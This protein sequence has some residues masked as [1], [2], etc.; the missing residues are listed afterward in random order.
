MQKIKSLFVLIAIGLLCGCETDEDTELSLNKSTGLE[1]TNST[2]LSSVP[3]FS[4]SGY[5]TGA[6]PSSYILPTPYPADQGKSN[7]CVGFAVGIGLYGVLLGGSNNN[8]SNFGSPTFVYNQ[9][10]VSTDCSDGCNFVTQ[11]GK[12]GALDLLKEKGIC[13]FSEMPFEYATYCNLLPNSTQ[14]LQ[15][16]SNKIKD[17]YRISST[18]LNNPSMVKGILYGGNPIIIGVKTD[19]GFDNANQN[20]VWNNRIGNI[21]RGHAL[22]IIGYDDSKQAF[23]IMN[24]WGTTWGDNGY[25]W[26]SYEFLSEVVIEAYWVD[27]IK[28]STPPNN[29]GACDKSHWG[30]LKLQCSLYTPVEVYF[31]YETTP[32]LKIAGPATVLKAGLSSGIHHVRIIKQF[33]LGDVK[34][35]DVIIEDCTTEIMYVY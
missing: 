22:L 21:G 31:D 15:A 19:A 2:V 33:G 13:T 18:D 8:P 24:S 5:G 26:I 30:N 28:S 1:L 4:Y 29:N 7:A 34:E 23:K 6:L 25:S 35:T 20:F 3:T 12:I 32:S 9:C 11:N 27:F 10:K 14:I 17:Y 16:K